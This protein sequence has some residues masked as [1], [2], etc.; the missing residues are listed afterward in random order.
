MIFYI[1]DIAIR[2]I[3]VIFILYMFDMVH[4]IN[5]IINILYIYI[6]IYISDIAIRL[7]DVIFILYMFDMVH[8]INK[9]I[10]IYIF[11]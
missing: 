10:N 9:I 4:I 2:L 3:D 7:I 11:D 6:Y 1:S 8:I 5:K